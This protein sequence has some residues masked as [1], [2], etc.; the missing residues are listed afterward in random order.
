MI[1]LGLLQWSPASQISVFS[2]FDSLCDIKKRL[3]L[4][5]SAKGLDNIPAIVLKT[6]APE[7]AA[8][9]AKLFQYSYNTGIYLTMWKIAQVYPVH[10]KQNKSNLANYCPISLL[11]I[12]SKVMEGVI[13]SA[14]KQHLLSDAQFGFHQ[15]HSAPD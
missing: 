12:I 1:H 3:G 13:N 14:I 6:C 8:P 4:L 5:I 2:Q 10:K 9:L 7:L 11:S 15:G